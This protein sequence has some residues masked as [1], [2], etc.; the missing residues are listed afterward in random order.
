MDIDPQ[1]IV[2]VSLV[3]RIAQ[4]VSR[5]DRAFCERD[6]RKGPTVY[7]AEQFLDDT[8]FFRER[9]HQKQRTDNANP[10]Y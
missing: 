2:N 3:S 7:E 9:C 5:H 8:Y 6:T 4:A 10:V 1:G